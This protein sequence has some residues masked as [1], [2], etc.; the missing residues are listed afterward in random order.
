MRPAVLEG[1]LDA[2]WLGGALQLVAV[3]L[4]AG[5][6]RHELY[7]MRSQTSTWAPRSEVCCGMYVPFRSSANKRSP[8]FVKDGASFDP[9]QRQHLQHGIAK[10]KE[11]VSPFC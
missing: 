9:V 2:V 5:V 10:G 8:G 6:S 11:R 7:A 4:G 1:S 3:R